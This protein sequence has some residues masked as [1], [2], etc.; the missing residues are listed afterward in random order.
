MLKKKYTSPPPPLIFWTI[1]PHQPLLPTG[2]GVETDWNRKTGQSLM[3]FVQKIEDEK[4]G[5][6]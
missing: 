4:K 5:A 3:I 1:S 2:C 6:L